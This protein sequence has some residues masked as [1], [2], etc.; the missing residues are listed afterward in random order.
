MFLPPW[1]HH[2]IHNYHCISH[3]P[4]SSSHLELSNLHLPSPSTTCTSISV[5]SWWRDF[6]APS[7]CGHQGPP[8][9]TS[10]HIIITVRGLSCPV[11]CLER[12]V[13]LH[14]TKIIC[15]CWNTFVD[16]IFFRLTSSQEEMSHCLHSLAPFCFYCFHL[17]EVQTALLASV[18]CMVMPTPETEKWQKNESKS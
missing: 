16:R 7:W 12:L 10:R 8:S 9:N 18:W 1:R 15:F 5:L 2:Q 4:P 11:S 6:N 3:R 17:F 13:P 14:K